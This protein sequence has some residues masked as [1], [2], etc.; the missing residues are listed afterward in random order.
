MTITLAVTARDESKSTDVIRKAGDVPAVVYGTKQEPISITLS[1]KEFD[2]VRKE[3][4]ESTIVELSGLDETIEVLI[5]DVAFHPVKQ[6]VTHVDFYA[7][8]RGKD[9]TT[10]VP[11]E[12]IG[13][14]PVE[15]SKEGTVTKVLHEIEVTCRPSALPSHIDVDIS[16]LVNVE[17]KIHI[18]DLKAPEGVTIE[19]EPEDPVAVVSAAKQVSEDDEE[20]AGEIDMDAIEVEE[21]GKGESED[22][23]E[24]SE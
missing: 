2:K 15:E 9:M 18:S 21:K 3:A 22:S 16:G 17:D 13:E 24:K 11:L 8:E 6:E 20:A 12:F 10:T 5:K 1:G 23:E 7:F 19:G 14:A 4:G